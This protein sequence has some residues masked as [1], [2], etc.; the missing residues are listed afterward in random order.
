MLSHVSFSVPRG[1][2]VGLIGPSGAG[3]TTC[4]D[5]LLGLLMPQEG[6][7]LVD[8]IPSRDIHRA[9]WHKQ[10][11]YVSQDLFLMN[12]TLR[13]NIAFYDD[14]ISDEE[15]LH[16]AEQAHI[17][18]MIRSAPAGLDTMVGDR[19]LTLS[20]GQRQR[21]VIARALARKPK[22]LILDEATS[23][24]DSESEQHIKSIIQG[25]KGS[26]TIVAVAHRL[27]TIVDADMLVALENGRV[28]EKGAPQELLKKADSYFSRVNAI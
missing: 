11:S 19:G 26:I 1:S 16:A 12:D 5:M 24:L 14:A 9:D 20:A 23:A 18:D 17:G 25:L 15:I 27:S 28:V 21:L 3:K 7:L 8:G 10:V 22:V 2:F 13:A 4:V 6:N